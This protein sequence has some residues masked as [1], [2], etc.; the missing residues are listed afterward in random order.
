MGGL[1]TVS[2]TTQHWLDPMTNCIEDWVKFM[3]MSA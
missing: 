2:L 1:V 3:I